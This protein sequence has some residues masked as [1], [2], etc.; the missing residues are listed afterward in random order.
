MLETPTELSLHL[1]WKTIPELVLEHVL[2]PRPQPV[3]VQEPVLV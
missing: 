3:P 2:E 1:S